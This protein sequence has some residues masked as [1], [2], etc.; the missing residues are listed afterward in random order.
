ML[1]CHL[2]LFANLN[3]PVKMPLLLTTEDRAKIA[4]NYEFIIASCDGCSKIMKKRTS[5]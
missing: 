5:V 4:V 2:A 1:T 3:N